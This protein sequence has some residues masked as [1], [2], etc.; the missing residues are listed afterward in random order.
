[1]AE[2]GRTEMELFFLIIIYPCDTSIP[3]DFGMLSSFLMLKSNLGNIQTKKIQN[4]VVVYHKIIYL[5]VNYGIS[6]ATTMNQSD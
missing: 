6:Q 3:T 1:M 2:T 5:P 4:A